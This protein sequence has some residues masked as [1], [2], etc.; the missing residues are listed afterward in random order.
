MKMFF[1][2]ALMTLAESANASPA[3]VGITDA[4]IL[5]PREDG[6]IEVICRNGTREL[7]TLADFFAN[8]VCPN[9]AT[10]RETGMAQ[11]T[12]RLDGDFD[13]VCRDQSRTR[14]T[15]EEILAGE[16][17]VLTEVPVLEDGIYRA[18][19]GHSNYFDQSVTAV[20]EGESQKGLIVRL[21]QFP[22]QANFTCQGAVCRGRWSFGT[23][24]EIEIKSAT[25]YSYSQIDAQ[26]NKVQTA[27][28]RK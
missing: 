24:A 5:Q 2:L 28:F 14:A 17:C 19:E 22:V 9:P 4:V 11:V 13:L 3:K 12:P 21:T 23:V 16:V 7:D 6:Y 27:L 8:A 1:V 20:M 26:G 10:S 15:Q 25:S 18:T